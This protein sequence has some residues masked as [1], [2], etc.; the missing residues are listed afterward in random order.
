MTVLV[1]RAGA[2]I[3]SSHDAHT[4][5]AA[6]SY[7]DVDVPILPSPPHASDVAAGRSNTLQCKACKRAFASVP[8]KK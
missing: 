6:S 5:Q 2:I 8:D 7:A 1:L 4:Q 3:G